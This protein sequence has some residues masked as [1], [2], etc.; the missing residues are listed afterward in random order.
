MIAYFMLIHRYP[1]QFKRLFKSIYHEKNYYVIHI[2]K[3]AGRKIFDEIDLFLGDYENASIL[4][5]KEAI[6]GGYSL[7]DAQLRGIE[8]LVTSGRTWDYFI[9]LSGQDFPLKSQE[10]IMGYLSAFD[11]CEFMKVV[12]QNLIR[13]ET[14]HRIKDYVEEIDGELVISTT[15]N[16]DFLTGV[17]PYIGNQWMI[18]S[19]NFCEFI[20]YSPELT[21][22]KEFYRNTLIADESFF[23]TVLMNTTFKSRIIYDDKRE[24]DWVESS[25]IK[26]RPR[27]FLTNDSKMLVNSKN[28][29]ARKF[30]ENIDGGILNILELNIKSSIIS[31][32]SH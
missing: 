20:T 16:R 18:L 9:N 15:S 27:N 32:F 21:V 22:F 26:L 28:L 13:P 31:T 8:K 23:Q 10:F 11:C 6:W 1:N 3:R 5:S 4:E 25:D 17:T 12:N 14:M 19:K 29:F 7:V 2:D 24:I 30:D